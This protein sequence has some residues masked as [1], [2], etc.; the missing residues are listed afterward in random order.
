M[1]RKLIDDVT[2]KFKPMD[3]VK[4]TITEK[5]RVLVKKKEIDGCDVFAQIDNPKVCVYVER[6]DL[7]LLMEEMFLLRV[8]MDMG[9]HNLKS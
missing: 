4:V 9:I 3:L 8:K 5:K 7:Q 2:S 6:K 1:Q